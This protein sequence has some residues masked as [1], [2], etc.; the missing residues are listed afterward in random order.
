MQL[1]LTRY[2]QPLDHFSRTFEP[3]EVG[4]EDDSYRVVA[5]VHL[6]FDIH[7]DK[8]RFRFEGNVRTELELPCSRC[9]EP[10]EQ[11]VHVEFDLRYLPLSENT[12]DEREIES[13]SRKSCSQRASTS[14]E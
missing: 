14:R 2:R 6:D 7:K 5:P 3:G 10:F 9:L 11:P 13:Y 8:D 1:D 12:G 4:N